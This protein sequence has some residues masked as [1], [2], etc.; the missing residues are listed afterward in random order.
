MSSVVDR[1]F[2]EWTR[3]KNDVEARIAVFERIRDIPY[4]IVPEI[5]GP[6]TYTGIF[7]TGKGSCTP[8]HLLLCEMYRRLDLPVLYVVYP[9]RWDEVELDYPPRLLRLARALPTGHH[10]ACLVDIEGSLRTIDATLD[11]ALAAMG[12]PVNE[13]WDGLSD[14]KLAIMPSG[15]GAIHHPSEAFLMTAQRDERSLEF[16][17]ALNRWLEAFRGS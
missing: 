4:A 6:E 17:R 3:G 2:S 14:T 10:L 12:L 13:G 8:K 5:S 11:P 1:K 15:E 7:R 9:F 16:D